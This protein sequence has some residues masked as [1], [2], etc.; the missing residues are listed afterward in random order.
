MTDLQ[1][2][3]IYELRKFGRGYKTIAKELN[4]PLSTV[5]SFLHRHPG[6][7]VCKYCGGPLP[8]TTSPRGRLFC[9][10]RCKGMWHHR[11]GKKKKRTC[12][13]CRKEF[14]VSNKHTEQFYCNHE[15]FYKSK[16]FL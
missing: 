10:D 6:Y 8:L 11:Y 13:F 16:K 2:Q 15:C 12:G 5:K 3:K 9:S 14:E 4:I 1:K 7:G